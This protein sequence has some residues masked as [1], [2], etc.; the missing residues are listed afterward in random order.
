MRNWKTPVRQCEFCL[1]AKPRTWGAG[2]AAGVP[3]LLG[4]IT[5]FAQTSFSRQKRYPH[6]VTDL[7]SGCFYQPLQLQRPHF[8]KLLEPPFAELAANTGMTKTT[9]R[10]HGVKRTTIHEH[11][12]GAQFAGHLFRLVVIR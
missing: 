1:A 8:K 9:K 3:F 6:P 2:P 10:G 4:K 11:L 5:R 7:T 12:A